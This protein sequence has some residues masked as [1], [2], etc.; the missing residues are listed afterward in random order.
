MTPEQEWRKLLLSKM[1]K[2]D[3]KV[4]KIAEEMNT[5]KVKVA[6]FSSA[7]GALITIAV[8]KFIS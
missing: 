4:D 3:E 2:L 8:Q 7:I 5:L 6:L 1:D